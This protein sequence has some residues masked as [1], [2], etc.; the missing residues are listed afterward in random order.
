MSSGEVVTNDPAK[1]SV[2]EDD[3]PSFKRVLIDTE[4]PVGGSVTLLVEL[5]STS[6]CTVSLAKIF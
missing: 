6:A 2:E 4:I 1:N 5:K 3:P